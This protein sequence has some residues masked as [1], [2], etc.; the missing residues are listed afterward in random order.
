MNSHEENW[1][2]LSRGAAIISQ[3]KPL[4]LVTVRLSTAPDQKLF[5]SKLSKIYTDQCLCLKGWGLSRL[6][7][8]QAAWHKLAQT[9]AHRAATGSGEWGGCR[10][11]CV[12]TQQ[13]A[14]AWW[15]SYSREEYLRRREIE[16]EDDLTIRLVEA[17]GW[18]ENSRTMDRKAMCTSFSVGLR[19]Q[20]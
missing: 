7:D 20:R 15:G 17:K 4:I 12:G 10:G 19:C 2:Q 18:Y 16:A 1:W 14:F 9:G 6:W 3:D 13:L 8:C 11:V 5:C